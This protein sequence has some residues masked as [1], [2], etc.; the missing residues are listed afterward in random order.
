MCKT[1]FFLFAGAG[2]LMAALAPAQS[3]TAR[4]LPP[5]TKVGVSKAIAAAPQ[6]TV[7]QLQ[8]LLLQ[9]YTNG[10]WVDMA[11]ITYSRYRTPLSPGLIRTELQQGTSWVLF[12]ANRLRYNTAG[13]VLTDTTDQY[14][15]PPYGPFAAVVNTYNTPTQVRWEWEL[16]R[17]LGG[18][19]TALLDSVQRSTHTYNA[20]GQL[21]QVLEQQ[22]A[23]R[24][25]TTTGRELWTYDAQGRINILEGQTT[26]DKGATWRLATRQTTTYNPESKAQQDIF[27]VANSAGSAYINDQRYTY[28]YDAQSRLAILTADKWL[29]AQWAVKSQSLSSYNATGDLASITFQDWDG[30]RF[31]NVQRALFTYQQVLRTTAATVRQSL[32]IVPNPSTAEDP[33]QLLLEPVAA[34]ATGAVYDQL[35][36][37]VAVLASTT[38]Q[39]ARGLLPLPTNLPAGLYVVHLRAGERQWQTRWQQL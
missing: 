38:A 10:A 19:S 20:A 4:H 21:I 5:G 14:Q 17:Q 7:S 39:A 13:L 12:A 1:S 15:L 29:N 32:A 9:S 25:F 23:A 11:R 31:L 22:Y 16:T 2:L 3:L 24:T 30:S 27:E 34:A 8:E 18:S 36:R 6:G 35:G 37:Q 28:Q 26:T 33:A